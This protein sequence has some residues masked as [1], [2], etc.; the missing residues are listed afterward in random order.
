MINEKY[1]PFSPPRLVG[2]HIFVSK[3]WWRTHT[4]GY[5]ETLVKAWQANSM[6][7][8]GLL[9]ENTPEVRR[10]LGMEEKNV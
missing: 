6:C 5:N 1:D 3:L 8:P 7:P 4:C 2:N 9:L 10:E